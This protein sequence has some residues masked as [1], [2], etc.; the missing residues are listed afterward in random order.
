MNELPPE[1]QV[2]LALDIQQNPNLLTEDWQNYFNSKYQRPLR[3][4]VRNFGAG[5]F[6]IK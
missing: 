1:N 2:E 3:G 4:Q 5:Q 6:N